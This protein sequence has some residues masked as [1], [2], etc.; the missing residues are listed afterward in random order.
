MLLYSFLPCRF[1]YGSFVTRT[2]RYVPYDKDIFNKKK[3][4]A[5]AIIS[6]CHVQSKRSK[7]LTALRRFVPV[8]FFGRCGD[9]TKDPFLLKC[10][11]SFNQTCMRKALL[12][13]KYY[14]AFE[15]SLCTDYI[16]EKLYK[17]L[18]LPIIPVVYGGADYSEHLPFKS[19]INVRDYKSAKELANYMQLVANRSDLYLSYFDWKNKYQL[20]GDIHLHRHRN[21]WSCLNVNPQ[22]FCNLCEYLHSSSTNHKVIT[23]LGAIW[24]KK[25]QCFQ[26]GTWLDWF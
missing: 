12:G 15:N 25:S 4:F 17:V 22:A 8:D 26:P 7:V 23:D 5:V 14:L 6:H 1:P 11:N 2:E 18:D 3:K 20:V 10:F 19:Y 13:Y 24:N 16:T 21:G 9:T